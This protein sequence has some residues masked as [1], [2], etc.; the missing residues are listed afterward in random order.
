MAFYEQNK[1]G[2]AFSKT[3]CSRTVDMNFPIHF[4]TSFELLYLEEGAIEVTVDGRSYFPQKGE[5]VLIPP[6]SAHSYKTEE[7]SVI[8]L[9]IFCADYLR[10]IYEETG[11]GVYRE[12]IISGRG[13]LFSG[14]REM[15]G[16]HCLFRAQLYLIA[17]E[18][19]KN[20]AIFGAVERNYGFTTRF[21]DYLAQHS[22]ESLHEIDVAKALSYH[23][24][25]LSYLVKKNFGASF[26][27]VLN[28]YRIRNACQMLREENKNITEVYL[29]V[30]FESQCAFNRNFRE[31][32]GVTPM[33]YRQG[34]RI[35]KNAHKGTKQV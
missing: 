33:K 35:G 16:D 12:P 25:Y 17:A 24:R 15:E 9:I 8:G 29:A 32:M 19:F 31:I 23:P 6:D 7:H 10:E 18:Y 26:R 27:A 3:R 2:A 34:Y 30:G 28:E 11:R 21:S 20:P 5:M 1:S 4:H 13:D 14:L 22:A